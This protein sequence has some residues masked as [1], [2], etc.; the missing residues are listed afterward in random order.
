MGRQGQMLA[1]LRGMF[2][3]FVHALGTLHGHKRRTSFNAE[4]S[5][6]AAKKRVTQF[7]YIRC[8]PKGYA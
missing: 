5:E 2:S 7:T 3:Y 1:T 8:T 4:Y 6:G